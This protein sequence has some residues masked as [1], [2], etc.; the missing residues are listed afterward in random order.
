M[1]KFTKQKFTRRVV[2]L[3]ALLLLSPWLVRAEDVWWNKDWAIRKKITVSTGEGGATITDPIGDAVLL[4]R[5]HE[6]NFQFAA[7]REDG[8]DLRVVSA[9]GKTLIPFHIE[10]FD[11][12]MNEG[13]VWVKVPGLKP[14]GK[15][16]IWLYYGNAGDKVENGASAKET[17]DSETALVYHFA[18]A[19]TPAVDST[20]QANNA[21]EA[22]TPSEGALIGGGL[23]FVGGPP[24]NI[25]TSPSLNWSAG[26]AL[27]W[28]A[29]VKAGVLQPNAVIFSRKDGTNAFVVGLDSGVPYLEVT[30]A[31]GTKRSVPGVAIAAGVWQHLSVI[32][33][34][35]SIALRLNGE[36][37]GTVDVP[38]PALSTPLQLGGEAD[39]RGFA[40]EIDELEISNSARPA[41]FIK[42]AVAGQGGGEA[43]EKLLQFAVDE[44]SGKASGGGGHALE[45]V[46]LFGDIA[47]NMM[48]DG[49]VVIF[50][51]AIMALVSWTVALKK[52]LYLNKIQEGGEEFLR[53]WKQVATDLTVLDHTD[54]ENV[55]SIGGNAGK[56]VQKLMHQSPLYHIYHI[57]SEE[58][59]HRLQ[60]RN[61]FNG[62]SARSIQAIK[63]SLDSGLTHEVHRLSKGLVFLTISI[64]G[65]PYVGLLGTVMGVMITFAVIAKSGEV[66]V[67]SIAPGIASALLATV[68]GLLVAIPALFIYSYLNSRIKDTVSNMQLFIDEFISK[69][70]EFY[71]TAGDGRA[72][73]RQEFEPEEYG[74]K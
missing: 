10:K 62:L 56:K 70:A 50:C 9:D 49:W 65:G 55:K 48:F 27:T 3:S 8:A 46:M 20:G 14:E 31:S 33:D 38:L 37:Y 30:D 22:G 42:L 24:V 28:S 15:T 16:D 63:A 34:G 59:R 1:E 29:W 7:A 17:Y 44:E 68:A 74:L 12:L 61:G 35:S 19:G 18:E 13:F 73:H 47:K 36:P 25:P 54:A 51:C 41:G 6:G 40:G 26:G 2:M 43:A 5:L 64:A 45:H 60:N 32:A 4:L 67:N 69:M 52:F 21:S 39:G 57:G 66:E 58:I 53:Q 71:P 72:P 11:T 23:R